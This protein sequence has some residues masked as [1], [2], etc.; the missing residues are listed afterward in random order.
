MTFAEF[1]L[2]CR[3]YE[4]KYFLDYSKHRLTAYMTYCSI[5]EK[6][7]KKPMHKWMPLPTDEAID[8]GL[9]VEQMREEW[10]RFKNMENK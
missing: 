1:L 10:N 8:I 3:G 6:G 5:P 2:A 9:T 4:R 7:K